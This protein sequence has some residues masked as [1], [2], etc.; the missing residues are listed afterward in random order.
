MTDDPHNSTPLSDLP[1]LRQ[2]LAS[3]K[4]KT[5]WRSLTELANSDAFEE[6]VRQEFPRQAN[7]LDSLNR[8]DFLKVLGASLAMAGLTA[9]APQDSN[10]IMPYVRPPEEV[11]PAQSQYFASSHILDG[12]A[13]GVLVETTMGRPIKIDGN[14]RHPASLGGSDVFMQASLLELY[15]PERAQQVLNQSLPKTWA[16]FLAAL[17]DLRASLGQGENLR[18][19]TGPVTSP[20]LQSQFLALGE[21][22]PQAR[23]YSFAP[24]ERANFNAAANQAFGQIYEPVYQFSNADVVLSLDNDFMLT[25]PG[26]LRY[27]REFA[28]RHQPISNEGTMNRLYVVES[29]LTLT[30]SNADHRLAVEPALV[31][32]FTA[33]LAARMGI[34][35]VTAPSGEVPGQSWLDPLVADLQRAGGS[36]LVLA[37]D[38]QPPAVHAMVFAINQALGAVGSTVNFIDP[39]AFTPLAPET[40][41]AQLVS[42]MNGGQVNTLI[43]LECNNPVYTA[44]ADLD[45][46]TALQK[47]NQSIYQGLF[48]DET[49]VAATWFIPGTH[50]LEMWGDA[51]AFDGTT[52]L[53]QPV[54]QPLY[55][56]KSPYELAAALLGQTDANGYDLVRQYWQTQ[57]AGTGSFDAAWRDALSNGVLPG[58]AAQAAA[59]VA[60]VNTAAFTPTSQAA[61]SDLSVVFEADPTIWDGRYSNNAWLQETPKPLTKLT[62]DNAAEISPETAR[63]LEL[64]TGDVIEIVAGARTVEAAVLIVPGQPNRVINASLGYGRRTGGSV[65]SGL[66][67]NAYALRESATPGFVTGVEIRKTGRT[68]PLATANDHWTMEN[69]DLVRSATVEEYEANPNFAHE[70]E[71]PE[72]NLLGEWEYPSVAWGMV[73]NLNTC[74]GCNACVVAC[75][76]EN[77]IPTVGKDQVARGRE[78]HW[79]RIDRYYTGPIESPEVVYAPI[80]C[81]HCEKAPCEP[82]CPVEATSHSAEGINEMTYNRCV[83]T[84]YCANNCPYKVRRFNFY[85][86]IDESI[87]SLRP[88]RNPD[89]TVRSRGVMEKC[90]YCV[91]RVNHARIQAEVEGRPI[92]DGEVTTACQDACPTRAIVFGNIQD[93]DSQVR[94]LKDLPLNYGMLAELGTQPRTTYLAKVRNTNP[95]IEDQA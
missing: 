37:G 23:W 7:L 88:M 46:G 25:E 94:K 43:M 32:V 15:D 57:P 24:L 90:T 1:S 52:S 44:P 29:S 92:R 21:Q 39:L 14:P 66:G 18:F 49:A 26:H 70:E 30:G 47:V 22:Y 8:R 72:A 95:L 65:M 10:K 85:K 35:G 81:M 17:G 60:E 31:E 63:Q 61:A 48:V 27:S 62:W 20:T 64:I 50:Y 33:A 38:R 13:R 71:I 53:I 16:D 42:E 3:K 11:T 68:Y 67:F 9:C 80:P 5:Y 12:Y 56:G 59:G 86:Y 83:G 74:I 40:S 36:A 41:L 28:Q 79:L 93:Q 87:L 54:I 78:M 73:I 19:L 6:L 84:R 58:T 4:G 51:R 34:A 2:Q 45:F 75:Q 76:A 77:N 55:A 82:V 89:V 91:Q 69:R